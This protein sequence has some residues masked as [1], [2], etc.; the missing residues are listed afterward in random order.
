M[1]TIIKRLGAADDADV[2]EEAA[3]VIKSGGLVAFPTETVYGLGA[4]ALNAAAAAKIY[5]AKNRPPN[6]PLIVHILDKSDV[7]RLAADVPYEAEKLIDAFW[8]GPLTLVFKKAAI[9]PAITCGGLDTVA[10]R[11]PSNAAA[12][13]L[14]R[15]SGTPVAAPSANISGAPSPTRAKHVIDDMNGKIDMIIDG[16]DCEIGIESTIVSFAEGRAELLRPGMITVEDLSRHIDID[17]RCLNDSSGKPKA[18]GMMY[19]HYS[20]KADM[21]LVCARGGAEKTALAIKKLADEALKTGKKPGIFISAR[22][23]PFFKPADDKNY[24]CLIAGSDPDEV[25]ANLYERLRRFDELGATDIY[26]EGY[27]NT[28]AWLSIMNRMT[29]AAGNK[30]IYV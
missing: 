30:I 24:I 11:L 16:G 13:E 23:E 4:D 3:R 29:K 17:A 26:A 19:R 27:E 5:K 8:P 6:N 1:L 15:R 22:L 18:P 10:V 14:I 2:F 9:V 7:Y 20:P 28:G 21:T 12:R 25:A